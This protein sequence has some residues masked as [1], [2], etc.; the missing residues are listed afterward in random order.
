MRLL[1]IL[2]IYNNVVCVRKL[3]PQEKNDFYANGA[4]GDG[5]R[6]FFMRGS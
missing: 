5:E 3:R 1:A 6:L 4:H 2:D